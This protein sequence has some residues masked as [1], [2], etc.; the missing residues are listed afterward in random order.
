MGLQSV[1]SRQESVLREF[2]VYC[3]FE[4]DMEQVWNGDTTHCTLAVT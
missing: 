1:L 4:H 2:L 3:Q